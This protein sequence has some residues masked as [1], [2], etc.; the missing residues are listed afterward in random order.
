MEETTRSRFSVI[1]SKRETME[2]NE[3]GADVMA[4]DQIAKLETSVREQLAGVSKKLETFA[5]ATTRPSSRRPQRLH[6]RGRARTS[7]RS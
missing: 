7:R 1:E 6:Q 3:P 5:A 2:L 4:R